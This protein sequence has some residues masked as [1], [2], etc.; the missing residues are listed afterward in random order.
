MIPNCLVKIFDGVDMKALLSDVP[1]VCKSWYKASLDPYRWRNLNF[2]ENDNLTNDLFFDYVHDYSCNSRTINSLSLTC[3]IE[4]EA[5]YSLTEI[6]VEVSTHCKKFVGLQLDGKI[7]I[8]M[9]E[10][11][12]VVSN[13]LEIKCV[14]LMRS[15]VPQLTSLGSHIKYFKLQ[16]CVQLDDG[17]DYDSDDDYYQNPW[18]SYSRDS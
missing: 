16:N 13:L 14:R 17:N 6:L 10:A 8:D 3:M 7:R 2:R 1:L 12:A 4:F 5:F 11:S 15:T 18:D 9:D